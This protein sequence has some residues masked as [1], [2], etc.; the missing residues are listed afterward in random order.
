MEN[1]AVPAARIKMYARVKPETRKRF[2]AIAMLSGETM[3]HHLE[4]LME[5]HV[6]RYLA[7]AG[8][9][10]VTAAKSL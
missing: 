7:Q 6:A 2:R 10:D 4:R 8:G 9:L 1:N 5:E 3:E